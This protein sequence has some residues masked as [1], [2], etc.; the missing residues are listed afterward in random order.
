MTCSTRKCK[1][2]KLIFTIEDSYNSQIYNDKTKILQILKNFISNA[3]KFT[4]VG[5][6]ELS[7]KNINE[8]SFKI[9][10]SDTGI[11]IA[12]E[13]LSSVFNAFVQA[14][15]SISREY[16]GTGLGL[17]ISKKNGGVYRCQ[18]NT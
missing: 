18:D 15:G 4:K 7:I 10:V 6:I 17:S 8:K 5:S 16:G 11:G 14:N 12:R 9:S 2:K 1:K 3:L 13:K